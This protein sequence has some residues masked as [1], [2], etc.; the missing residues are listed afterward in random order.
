MS[1]TVHPNRN[2][3]CGGRAMGNLGSG[4]DVNRYATVAERIRLFYSANPLG[5]I[6]TQL[7]ERT[8]HEI[9]FKALVFRGP[10]DESAAATGW[11]A[12][13]VGD[14]EINAVACLENTETSAVGRA[15]AN[16][17]FTASRE[18]PSVEEMR[19]AARVRARD[20]RQE[21][22]RRVIA[23][24]GSVEEEQQVQSEQVRGRET[25][26]RI[27]ADSLQ[28]E[29]DDVLDVLG[30]I[31]AAERVGLRRARGEGLRARVIAGTVS[32]AARDRWTSL[33]RRWI[34]KRRLEALTASP[35][36]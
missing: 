28:R 7:I 26:K 19:K 11:A 6:E 12:E 21:Q 14:S 13:R 15:L 5:R 34:N 23:L 16:L 2:R 18:R 27:D 10:N 31:R 3:I 9:V 22:T 8:E 4:F 17:G 30:L 25:A 24:S 20:A 35:P 36:R 32:G 1:N 29:A 33:L